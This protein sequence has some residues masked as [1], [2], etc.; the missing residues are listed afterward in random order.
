MTGDLNYKKILKATIGF[1]L[2]MVG[3]LVGVKVA[4]FFIP[5]L[6][7][8][9]I[10][11]I[12]R[13]PV[14]FLNNKFK[15]NRT[16]AVIITMLIFILIVGAIFYF[17]LAALFREVITLSSIADSVFG[18]T[19]ANIESV[20]KEQIGRFSF[21]FN[22]LQISP[23]LILRIENSAL[24]IINGLLSTLMEWVK[25][26]GNFAI[27]IVVNFPTILIYIIITILSTFFM[28]CDSKYISESLEKYLPLKWLKKAEDISNGL[29]HSLGSY[30][31]AQGILITITFCELLIGFSLFD[32]DY[33][34]ILAVTIAIID[35]LPILGT[36]TV[37]IPWGIVLLI[38]GN[39]T[40]G[41][42]ILGLYLFVLIVRQLIEPKIVGHQIGVYPLLTLIAMY[43]GVKFLGLFGVIVGPIVL[44][45]LKNVLS[46]V[47][48][49]G[50]LKDLFG[51]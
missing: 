2:I 21:F 24:D 23:E 15:L 41:F 4:I 34:V 47:Y 44:I 50:V 48:E 17:F 30:L 6:I 18:R 19:Y 11:K 8:F 42:C 22:S 36:G 43:T 25:N 45:I 9:I 38:M 40:L 7:A 28:S 49:K 39:Y 13:K 16:I 20:F 31:K 10:S 14:D 29:F 33:A 1:A 12:I 26:A 27:S 5:F 37:L 35:A 46:G 32:V 3:I 51:N